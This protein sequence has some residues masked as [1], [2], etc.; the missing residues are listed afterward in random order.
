MATVLTIKTDDDLAALQARLEAP[1]EVLD[2]MGSILKS[3]SLGAFNAQKFGS[4][5]WPARYHGRGD[6]FINLA[7]AI[8]DLSTGPRVK[9]RRFDKRPAGIDS[10]RLMQSIE[11]AVETKGTVS[12]KAL[13]EYAGKFQ[14]GGKSSIDV[15]SRTRSNLAKFLKSDTGKPYRERMGFLFNVTEYTLTTIPRP[16]IGITDEGESEAR[17]AIEEWGVGDF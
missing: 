13:A 16:F 4:F 3:I 15:T 6:P 5:S 2:A 7:G 8:E 14:K 12:V 9:A 1:E 11:H 17:E 10:G